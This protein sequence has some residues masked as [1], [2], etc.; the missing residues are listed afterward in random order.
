[1]NLLTK[2]EIAEA[3]LLAELINQAR[4]SGKL[5]TAEQTVRLTE[6]MDKMV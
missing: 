1:M 3:K 6:L 4:F 2:E 5:P